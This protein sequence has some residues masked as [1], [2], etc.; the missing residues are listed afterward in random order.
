LEASGQ[1]NEAAEHYREA[2]RLR[3]EHAAS[4]NNLGRLLAASGDA[5]AALKHY[6]MAIELDPNLPEAHNNL[7]TLLLGFGHTRAAIEQFEMAL[8]LK[9]DSTAYNN[10]A[11]AYDQDGRLADA[12]EMARKAIPLARAEGNHALA[13]RLQAAI[14]SQGTTAP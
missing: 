12:L 8:R 7:G 1:P 11:A 4:H 2:L 13:D 9:V 3:P 6:E 14:E 5:E 10:L